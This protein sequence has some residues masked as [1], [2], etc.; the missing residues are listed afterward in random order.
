MIPPLASLRA[1]S[2]PEWHRVV[3]DA[4]HPRIL[5]FLHGDATAA[6]ASSGP[7]GASPDGRRGGEDEAEDEDEQEGE[8][9]G[10]TSDE[11]PAE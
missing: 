4:L 2:E 8:G 5:H 10:E 3:G 11:E 9:E 6:I 1:M 7:H